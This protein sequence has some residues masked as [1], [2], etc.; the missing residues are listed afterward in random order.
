L[1]C[2]LIKLEGSRR[3]ILEGVAGLSGL[4]AFTC[5]MGVVLFHHDF[6]S[7][8]VRR[9]FGLANR[10]LYLVSQ[11]EI[12]RERFE[13]FDAQL[14]AGLR[15][16]RSQ[17]WRLSFAVA[18]ICCDWLCMLLVLHY[19]FLAVGCRVPGEDLIAG[20]GVGMLATLIPIL[21][22]GMGAMEPTMAAAF[23][24]LGVPFDTAFAAALLFRLLYYVLP[25]LL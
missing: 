3:Q 18:C 24:S 13:E 6:R 17:G 19:A 15:A 5:F 10:L 12:P 20:F 11:A 7:R 4:A 8:L 22:A 25:G 1:F 2:L 16:V 21:P 23:D 9:L 14:N